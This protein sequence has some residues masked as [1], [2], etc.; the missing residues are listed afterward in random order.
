MPSKRELEAY[1]GDVSQVFGIRECSLQGGKATGTR[2]YLLNNGRGLELMA[3]T[4]KCFAIPQLRFKGV[5]IGF[6][7]KTGICGPQFF[8]EEGTRGFLRN[9][10]A[11]FLTTCGLSYVG[12]P[13]EEND[14][15]NGLH[16][17]ISNTPI[18]NASSGVTWEG[19]TATLTLSGTAREGYLFGPNLVIHKQLSMSTAENK[20]VLHDTVENKGFEASPL[21]L[22]YHFNYGY[23]MLDENVHIYT[24]YDHVVPRDERSAPF[25]DAICQYGKPRTDTEEVVVFRTMSDKSRTD[26]RTLV[27]N[28]K[29]G[30]AVQMHLNAH[31]LPIL[32]QWK[33]ECA[34][35]YA[36]GLEPGTGHVGGRINTRRDG[37]LMTIAPGEEKH[38]DVTVDFLDDRAEIEARIATLP[39]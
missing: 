25:A 13:G 17:V 12:T 31:Q 22:L 37:L 28:P 38:F 23:P 33:S 20:L 14:Q 26:G 4:D 1:C 2:A 11:G 8:Q 39:R 18:E 6:L 36:L 35:D 27:Y 32:N 15:K 21:M 3:L 24:N 9:F 7:T 5:N 30:I 16:G 10:E 19:D 29:L 34:G